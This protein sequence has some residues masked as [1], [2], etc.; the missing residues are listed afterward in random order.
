[1]IISR[2]SLR[3]ILD[4]LDS[5]QTNPEKLAQRMRNKWLME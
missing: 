4:F 3:L 5:R 1:M 2:E